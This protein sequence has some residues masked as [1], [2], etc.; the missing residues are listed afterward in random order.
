MLDQLIDE[1]AIVAFAD[2]YGFLV[3][4]R[5]IDAEISQIPGT[6]GLN[7]EFSE[8]A[9]LQFLSQQQLTDAAVRQYVSADLLQRLMLTPVATD[10]RVPVGHGDALCVD[11][12]GSSRRRGRDRPDDRLLGRPQAD[13]RG[14]AE[15]LFRQPR[16]AT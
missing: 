3:S 6:K 9:Y 8:Q 4:K 7:G 10:V 14:P 12:A 16:A 1:R 2:K 15:L 13:R 11:A 5:L